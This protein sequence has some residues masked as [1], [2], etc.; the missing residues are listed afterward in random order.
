MRNN[1]ENTKVGEEGRGGTPGTRAVIFLQPM[2]E[3]MVEKAF[4]RSCGEEPCWSRYPHSPW[5]TPCPISGVYSQ[6][7]RWQRFILKDPRLWE[8]PTLQIYPEGLWHM[9]AHARAEEQCE[10][11]GKAEMNF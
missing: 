8:G 3:T 9:K 10:E 1:P 7:P 5:R 6:S 4:P 2:E 11:E